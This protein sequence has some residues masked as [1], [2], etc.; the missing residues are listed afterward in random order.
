MGGSERI[1]EALRS[2]HKLRP[3]DDATRDE[4]T[5]LVDRLRCLLLR[6]QGQEALESQVYGRFRD[7]ELAH[8]LFSATF[9]SDLP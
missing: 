1:K 5:D 8:E 3:E 2:L 6:I 9:E 4:I 7:E